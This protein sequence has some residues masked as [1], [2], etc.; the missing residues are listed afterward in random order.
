MWTLGSGYTLV[1]SLEMIDSGLEHRPTFA[2]GIS[3][4]SGR[5][6]FRLRTCAEPV[7][8]E[9]ELLTQPSLLCVG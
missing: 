9:E 8:L 4:P 6:L 7:P 3:E 2:A 5:A 1:S